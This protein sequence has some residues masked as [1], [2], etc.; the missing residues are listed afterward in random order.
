MIDIRDE[1]PPD[2][3]AVYQVVSSAFGQSAEAELVEELRGAG[4]SVISLVAEE[5]GQIVGHVLLS[6]MDAPFPAL[7]LGPRIGHS[8]KTAVRC[9]ISAD[10]ES[11]EPCSQRRLGSYLRS[12]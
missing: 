6:N 11:R 7:A 5:D 3:K 9:W 12:G 2:W 10:Y 4:D 8:H 1:S